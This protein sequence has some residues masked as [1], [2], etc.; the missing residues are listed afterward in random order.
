MRAERAFDVAEDSVADLEG[1]DA[2]ADRLDFSGELGPEDPS[3]RLR[4][5]EPRENLRMNGLAAR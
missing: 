2:T 1:G 5:P 4:P 3:V